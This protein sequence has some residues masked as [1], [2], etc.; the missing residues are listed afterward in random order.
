[1][2]ALAEMTAAGTVA[3]TL[4]ALSVA[5]SVFSLVSVFSLPTYIYQKSTVTFGRNM[6]GLMCL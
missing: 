6:D 5:L 2:G 4:V 3:E 1:M